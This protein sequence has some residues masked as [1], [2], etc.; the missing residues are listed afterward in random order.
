MALFSTFDRNRQSAALQA[1]SQRD[2]SWRPWSLPMRRCCCRTS[3]MSRRRFL[4]H[5]AGTSWKCDDKEKKK[6][7]DY[8]YW[9]NYMH[10]EY[11]ALLYVYYESSHSLPTS[12]FGTMGVEFLYLDALK[13]QAISPLSHC[14]RIIA[15]FVSSFALLSRKLHF[16]PLPYNNSTYKMSHPPKEKNLLIFCTISPLTWCCA[17]D[18]SLH[19]TETSLKF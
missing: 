17:D 9:V 11:F 10:S 7:H 14:F 13:R 4:W 5:I 6:H 18:C 3:D 8:Y 2:P 12:G 16:Y 1:M 19:F 15:T